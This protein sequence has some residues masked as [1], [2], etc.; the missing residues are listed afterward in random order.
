MVFEIKWLMESWL[1]IL[2]IKWLLES[3][4]ADF[5]NKVAS[6]IMDSGLRNKMPGEVMT[7]RL[8][9]KLASGIMSRGIL[10]KMASCNH[11]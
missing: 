1:W 5:W 6:C 2:E 9:N 10:N 4:L 8:W 7:S 11:G 3:W